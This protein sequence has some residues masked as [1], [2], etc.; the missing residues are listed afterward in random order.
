MNKVSL[1][2]GGFRTVSLRR[3]GHDRVLCLLIEVTTEALETAAAATVAYSHPLSTRSPTPQ[4][5]LF[6][7]S[8]HRQMEL[9]D[10][11]VT[12]EI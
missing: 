9:S 1:T 10:F 11:L 7:L 8:S 3:Q 4:P 2:V 5:V 12:I 6:L